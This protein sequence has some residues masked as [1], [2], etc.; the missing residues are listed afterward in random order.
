MG[1]YLEFLLKVFYG[2]IQANQNQHEMKTKAVNLNV[3][4]VFSRHNFL[5]QKQWF[6]DQYSF[7]YGPPGSYSILKQQECHYCA[8]LFTEHWLLI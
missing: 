6:V 2:R 5:Y 8:G 4:A 3:L 1:S 7:G